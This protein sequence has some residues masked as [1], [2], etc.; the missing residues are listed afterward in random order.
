MKCNFVVGQ[1]V[2]CVRA[3]DDLTRSEAEY[4]GITLPELGKIYTVRAVCETL[5]NI[6]VYLEEIINPV[7]PYCVDGLFDVVEQG[8][9]PDRFRPLEKRKTDI[10]CFTSMLTPAG[11]IPVDA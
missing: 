6:C 1:K 4:F 10:S 5:G 7:R 8:F 2:V 3:W 11:R 9:A